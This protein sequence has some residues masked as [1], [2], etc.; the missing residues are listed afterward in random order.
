MDFENIVNNL[1][2]G[3][4]TLLNFAFIDCN[5]QLMLSIMM[6]KCCFNII[7]TSFSLIHHLIFQQFSISL[8]CYV[9][10]LFSNFQET[11]NLDSSIYRK[12]ISYINI[13]CTLSY[14]WLP[15]LYYK[16]SLFYRPFIGTVSYN[17]SSSP[18]SIS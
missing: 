17:S 4:I 16:F 12:L 5:F 13:T 2:K 18:S 15:L 14:G 8:N 1:D 9:I 11:R 10:H 3:L 6:L 7:I